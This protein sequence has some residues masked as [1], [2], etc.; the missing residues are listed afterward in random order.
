MFHKWIQTS[1][2]KNTHITAKFLQMIQVAR[3]VWQM[4]NFSII[5][6]LK[7]VTVK[8]NRFYC[9]LCMVWNDDGM[10][11]SHLKLTPC[12]FDH[13]LYTIL[14]TRF[15]FDAIFQI[16]SLSLISEWFIFRLKKCKLYLLF[17]ELNAITESSL[18]TKNFITSIKN[19]IICNS[20]LFR[21]IK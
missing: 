2:A 6:F 3:F 14:A 5:V 15:L 20:Y 19:K 12:E 1:N 7:T 21:L 18:Y 16:V 9:V 4:N 17:S 11:Q 13:L 8:G 10:L